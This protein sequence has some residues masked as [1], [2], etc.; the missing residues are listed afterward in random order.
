[1]SKTYLQPEKVT[2]LD[3]FSTDEKQITPKFND[4]KQSKITLLTV[5]MVL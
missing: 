2:T 1:M 3:W 5:L 4:S